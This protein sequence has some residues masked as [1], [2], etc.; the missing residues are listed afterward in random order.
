MLLE[1]VVQ[2][3]WIKLSQNTLSAKTIHCPIQPSFRGVSIPSLRASHSRTTRVLFRGQ[4]TRSFLIAFQVRRRELII[5]WRC[6][7]DPC[8]GW[9]ITLRWVDLPR[10]SGTEIA[11]GRARRPCQGLETET[12]TLFVSIFSGCRKRREGLWD[13]GRKR[14]FTECLWLRCY[15]FG[16]YWFTVWWRLM[17][18]CNNHMNDGVRVIKRYRKG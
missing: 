17:K 11:C 5:A 9:G 6:W 16:R 18:V 1:I 15:S 12:S 4:S 8:V 3:A 10:S 14:L 13:S 2:T 7:Q